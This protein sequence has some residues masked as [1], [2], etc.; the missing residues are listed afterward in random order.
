M[1][2]KSKENRKGVKNMTLGDIIAKYR[3]DNET[4]MD[5]FAEMSS[6]LDVFLLYKAA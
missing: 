1:G 5:K 2:D 3:A 4:S 6:F